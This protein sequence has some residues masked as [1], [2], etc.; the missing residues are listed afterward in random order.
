MRAVH[1][2]GDDAVQHTRSS[3]ISGTQISAATLGATITLQTSPNSTDE[4]WTLIEYTVPPHAS[5]IRPHTPKESVT[6]FCVLSGTLTLHFE[7]RKMKAQ[8]GSFM[9]VPAGTV[10][11]F[12]NDNDT[13]A[14]FLSVVSPGGFERSVEGLSTYVSDRV[15]R[16]SVDQNPMSA[17]LA[18]KH[19]PL[20]ALEA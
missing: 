11:W 7:D 18:M 17:P 13:P 16:S 20:L 3:H 2:A 14:T 19:R 10:R 6:G 4:S 5:V 9:M 12:S 8:A 15:D 1:S